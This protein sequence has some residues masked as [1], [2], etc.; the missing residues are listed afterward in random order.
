VMSRGPTQVLPCRAKK[1]TGVSCY[2]RNRGCVAK[3]KKIKYQKQ[4][5]GKYLVDLEMEGGPRRKFTE[6]LIFF[7]LECASGE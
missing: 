7:G 4:C 3:K 2:P 5:E 6:G 1:P